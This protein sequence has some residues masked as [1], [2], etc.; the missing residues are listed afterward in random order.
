MGQTL[1]ADVSGIADSDGLTGVSFS[2]QWISTDGSS[3][4]NLADT[5][6]STYT[7]VTAN[8]GKSIKLQVTFTD[9]A[10]NA[11]SLTSTATDKPAPRPVLSKVWPPEM[12]TPAPSRTKTPSPAG[13]TTG[14]A[15]PTRRRGRSRASAW[16]TTTPA[17]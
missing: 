16:A 11:E 2:Y 4:S 12:T 9:D 5:T 14:T 15:R 7:F 13:E 3:D 6:G 10:G 1:T 17:L 8:T